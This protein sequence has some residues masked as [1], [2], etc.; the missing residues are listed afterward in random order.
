MISIAEE[1]ERKFDEAMERADVILTE[2]SMTLI[3]DGFSPDLET[4]WCRVHFLTFECP[5]CHHLHSIDLR[6]LDLLEI[7][8]QDKWTMKGL[9]SNSCGKFNI[10]IKGIILIKP[11]KISCSV[12]EIKK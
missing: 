7:T 3:K 10:D 12:K 4:S 11:E 5:H 2:S 8:S 6:R 9:I 1:L